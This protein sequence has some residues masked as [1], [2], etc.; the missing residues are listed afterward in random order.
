LTY[1]KRRFRSA[2]AWLLFVFWVFWLRIVRQFM[3]LNKRD[4]C[5]RR[6]IKILQQLAV[7]SMREEKF[8]YIT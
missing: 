2:L 4:A 1:L 6:V 7:G 8:F 3:D 5:S